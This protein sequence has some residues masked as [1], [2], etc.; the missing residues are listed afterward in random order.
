L[1][2]EDTEFTE[3][4]EKERGDFG[5]RVFHVEHKRD[6]LRDR[7]KIDALNWQGRAVSRKGKGIYA[8][9]EVARF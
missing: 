5:M 3:F 1:T 9:A 4:T 7:E 6:F 8:E 2:T